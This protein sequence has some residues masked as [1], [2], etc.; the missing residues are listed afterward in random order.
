MIHLDPT[1]VTL[2]I[3]CVGLAVLDWLCGILVGLKTGTF[4]LNRLPN[5]LRTTV[6][7]YIGGLLVLAVAQTLGS[8]SGLPSGVSES[9]TGLFVGASA[10]VIGG[11]L[12]DIVIKVGALT[13]APPAAPP[14]K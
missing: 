13:A 8:V 4:A 6:L 10:T 5:Q 12:H 9:L 14:A 1:L 3:V 2:L 11:C 7:P